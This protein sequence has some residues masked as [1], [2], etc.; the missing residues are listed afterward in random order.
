MILLSLQLSLKTN[1]QAF[2]SVLN[3]MNI[4]FAHTA[5]PTR[6][7]SP[8]HLQGGRDWDMN[9]LHTQEIQ[10]KHK[11]LQACLILDGRIK[12]RTVQKVQ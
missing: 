3:V 4:L 11:R 5:S 8:P 12:H 10:K 1:T 6:L 7:I 2:L 9:T